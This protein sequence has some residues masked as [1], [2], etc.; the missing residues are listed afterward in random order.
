MG[1]A[2]RTAAPRQSRACGTPRTIRT[3]ERRS[4]WLILTLAL[5]MVLAFSACAGRGPAAAGG[6][7]GS[8]G[9]TQTSGQTTGSSGQ[10]AQSS[11]AAAVNDLAQVDAD[12]GGIMGSM[13]SSQQTASIDES[14]SDNEG[15]VPQP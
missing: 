14:A 10:S 7:G 6:V 8:G 1:Q 2:R 15:N 4:I 3:H 5:V 13:D 11:Q 9:S 12:L